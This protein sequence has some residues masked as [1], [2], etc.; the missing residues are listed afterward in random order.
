QAAS[1]I[2]AEMIAS[3]DMV[4][5]W[6]SPRAAAMPGGDRSPLAGLQP[7]TTRSTVRGQSGGRSVVG[8]GANA[9]GVAL[10]PRVHVYNGVARM[11]GIDETLPAAGG[12]GGTWSIGTLAADRYRI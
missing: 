8:A 10:V 12:G 4:T 3:F 7:R 9:R 11:G 6:P 5:S 1:G 2:R